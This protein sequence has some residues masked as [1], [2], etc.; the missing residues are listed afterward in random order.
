MKR[1]DSRG[2]ELSPVDQ[3]ALERALAMSTTVRIQTTAGC[4]IA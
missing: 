2:R 4:S 3:N 1:T